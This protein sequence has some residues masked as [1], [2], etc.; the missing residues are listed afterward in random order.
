MLDQLENMLT[1]DDN[2]VASA[3]SSTTMTRISC[4]HD[5]PDTCSLLV[6]VDNASKKAVRIEGNPDHPITK[7]F[8]CNKVNHYLE[9]VYNDNRVLYPRRRVGAKGPGARF[10]RISWNE[11]LETITDNFKATIAEYGPDAVQPYSYSGTL[12]LL[13]FMGM[14]ERFFNKMG[15]A[16]L[17]RTICVYAAMAAQGYT[18]GPADGTDIEDVPNS[19]YII[20]WGSNLVST[21]VHHVPFIMEAKERGAKVVVIDPRVTRTSVMLADWHVQPKP[22]TDGALALAMMHVIFEARLQ[23]EDFLREQTI[24]WERLAADVLPSYSP[25]AVE[26]ICGVSAQD[27][28]KLALEY[29]S[30]KK[31]YI[32]VGIGLNRHDNGGMIIRDVLL[33]P[34][35]TGAWRE[36]CGGAIVSTVEEMWNVDFA[37]L[38]RTDLLGGRTPRSINMVE[39]GKAL[40]DAALSPPIKSL[41]VW[42]SDP[43]N[44]TPDTKDTRRGLMRDDL[45]TVVHDTF[46]TDTCDYA[47]I[48]LPADT[49]LEHMDLHAAYGHYYFGLSTPAID[50]VGESKDNQQL[51]REL[52]R[53]MGYNEDCFSETDEEMIRTLINPDHNPLFEGVSFE[54]SER[55]GLGARKR[56]I[57]A[58]QLRENRLAN[59]VQKDR[60]LFGGDGEGRI[61]AASD[62]YSGKGGVGGYRAR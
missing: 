24:G 22:G 27:I 53:R 55:E 37:Y 10:A 3:N 60:D 48:I 57:K 5:C 49:Q 62:L 2:A 21:G 26:S 34:A 45:F 35:I 56:R 33:L 28:R 19:E 38:C 36:K 30:T 39:I 17:E 32:R 12:G 59:A 31:S 8:L 11:A 16:R 40:N 14:S 52:A 51:F 23:D 9:L 13:G 44:C 1:H 61:A 41:F 43:A 46:F 7:G 42:N 47:D 4:P 18:Y 20:L 50:P 15:A 29:A 54:F 58:P 6:T 25:E